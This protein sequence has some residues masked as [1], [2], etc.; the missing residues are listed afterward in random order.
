VGGVSSGIVLANRHLRAVGEVRLPRRARHAPNA[1]RTHRRRVR[2]PTPTI[3]T[4]AWPQRPIRSRP[5]IGVK[6]PFTAGA[7]DGSAAQPMAMIALRANLMTTD[8][9]GATMVLKDGAGRRAANLSPAGTRPRLDG[10]LHGTD[11]PFTNLPYPMWSELSSFCRA[12]PRRT[13]R[14]VIV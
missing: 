8:W 4:L 14:V 2:L 5:G 6:K 3:R 13:R 9:L 7:G 10:E 12:S 1:S 11:G